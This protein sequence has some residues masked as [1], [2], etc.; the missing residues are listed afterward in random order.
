MPGCRTA[1]TFAPSDERHEAPSAAE[2]TTRAR[3]SGGPVRHGDSRCARARHRLGAGWGAS[4]VNIL[5]PS[6]LRRCGPRHRRVAS[7]EGTCGDRWD[8]DRGS[9]RSRR[10]R[11]DLVRCR[12]R[13]T[14]CM[15]PHLP[16]ATKLLRQ[17]SACCGHRIDGSTSADVCSCAYRVRHAVSSV[18]LGGR[19]GNCAGAFGWS[20]CVRSGRVDSRLGV[21]P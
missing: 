20:R 17:R 3:S 10:C 15:R 16:R 8:V 11:A 9:V 7:R 18:V 2:T 19:S 13:G 14:G 1:T 4:R 12:A 21:K 6:R 5:C